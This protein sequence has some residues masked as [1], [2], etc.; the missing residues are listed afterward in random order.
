M[1]PVDL[2]ARLQKYAEKAGE[3]ESEVIRLAVDK[4]LSDHGED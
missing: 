3:S 1:A 4:Y 2:L